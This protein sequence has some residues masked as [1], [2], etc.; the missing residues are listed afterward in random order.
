M[1]M[2]VGFRSQGTY[3][4]DRIDIHS[5]VTSVN[6]QNKEIIAEVPKC[7]SV[8]IEALTQVACIKHKGSKQIFQ[9]ACPLGFRR[10]VDL[11][12]RTA[13]GRPRWLSWMLV[14][15]VIRRLRVRPR[16]IGNFLSLRMITKY[17]LRS[18][19]PFRWF[20]KSSC[21]FLAKECAQNWFTA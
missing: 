20:K 13:L 12:N 10:W 16:R 4:N 7:P 9:S 14:Q 3:I 17:F 8:V 15:L 19:S 18:F 11:R 21:Q 5:Y 1:L 6:Y 2:T